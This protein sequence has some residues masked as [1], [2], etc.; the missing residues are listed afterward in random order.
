MSETTMS[1]FQ[2][3]LT[4]RRER[5]RQ[6]LAVSRRNARLTRQ[7]RRQRSLDTVG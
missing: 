1:M 3:E 7:L 2:A 4:Y 5:A 6:G